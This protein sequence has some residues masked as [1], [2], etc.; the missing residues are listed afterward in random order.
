[1]VERRRREQAPQAQVT[2]DEKGR[3]LEGLLP[4]ALGEF[5]P[6]IAASFDLVE[7]TVK[8]DCVPSVCTILKENPDLAFDFLLCL[9]VVDYEEHLQVVYH[10]YSTVKKHKMVLKASVP[11]EE[12][13][14][15]SVISVWPG[16]DWF[17]REGHDLFGVVFEGHPNMTPLLL[18]EGFEGFPG[19]KS[20]DFND[21]TE[22]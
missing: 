20:Y 9:C 11:T 17:E 21:Y 6:E 2:L 10:L 13:S 8:P 12:P 4:G 18:Y 14:I 15:P 5:E 3:I 22:W 19:R 16:A 1:V 7:A